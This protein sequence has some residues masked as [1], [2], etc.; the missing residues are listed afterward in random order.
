MS[1]TKTIVLTIT[2]VFFIIVAFSDKGESV[3]ADGN[4]LKR[5]AQETCQACHKTDSNAPVDTNSIKTHNSANTGSAKWGPNGWGVAGG[6]YGQFVCTT[7]HTPHDTNNIYLI[8]ETITAPNSPT[9]SFPGSTV[10][11]RTFSGIAGAT[12]GVMGDDFG[13]PRTSSTRICEICH[14]QNKFHN[15]NSANNAGGNAHNN[16]TDCTSCHDHKIAF[17]PSCRTCHTSPPA[18]GKHATHFGAGSAS[19]GNTTIQSSSS[20]YGFSCGICHNGTHRNTTANPH[21]VEVIFTGIATQDGATTAAYT[22]SA[23]SVDSPSGS[24]Y[25]FNYSNGMCSNTYC[26]GNYPGSGKNASVTFNTGTAV[27]G[28]CHDATN[29]TVPPSGSHSKHALSTNCAYPCIMCHKGI[30]SGS[31]PSGYTIADKSRHANGSV[32]W[33]FDTF[34]SSTATYSITSGNTPPSNGTTPRAYGTCSNTYCHSNGTAVSSGSIPANTSATWGS[35]TLACNSCHGSGTNNGMPNY[36]NGNPKANVHQAHVNHTSHPPPYTSWAFVM[37]CK[38][39]HVGTTTDDT[40]IAS[41]SLHVNRAYDVQANGSQVSFDPVSFTYTPLPSGGQCF[42][43]SCH[44]GATVY[45]GGSNGGTCSVSTCHQNPYYGQAL[46][47]ISVTPVNPRTE[48]NTAQQFS[49]IALY[50]NNVTQDITLPATWTSSNTAIAT[51]A[52]DPYSYGLVKTGGSKGT[53]T[54]TAQLGNVSG[55]TTLEVTD[56]RLVAIA[57]TPANSSIPLGNTKQF[58]AMGTY[59]DNSVLDITTSVSWESSTNAATIS[60][61][62]GSKGLATSKGVG[63][64]TVT[65]RLG[66]ISGNT[67]LTITPAQLASIAV[68][69]S[70]QSIAISSTQQFIATGIYTDGSMTDYTNQVTWSS[71][72][73]AVATINAAG[74][75]TGVGLSTSTITA[76]DP[77]TL[78]S[79]STTLTVVTLGGTVTPL[80]VNNGANWNDYVKNNG[81][82]TFT[83]TDTPCDGTE[84]SG[85]SACLHGGEMRKVYV[86]GKSTC[87]G[88][89]AS[90]ALGVFNWSCDGSVNPVRMI[91]DGLQDGKNLSD[92]IDLTGTP[93]WKAN[94]V[95]VSDSGNPYLATSYAVW[96]NN[97]VVV[98]NSGGNLT[99]SGTIYVNVATANP[100]AGYEIMADKVSLVIAPFVTLHTQSYSSYLIDASLNLSYKFLW[101]EGNFDTSNNGD[102]TGGGSNI[103]VNFYRVKFSVLRNVKVTKSLS[104]SG[105]YNFYLNNVSNSKVTNCSCDKG[106]DGFDLYTSS[107]NTF[108]DIT[109]S[110]QSNYGFTVNGSSINTFAKMKLFGN[111]GGIQIISSTNNSLTNVIATN[112]LG[113]GIFLTG[114]SY[115]TFKNVIASNNKGATGAGIYVYSSSNNNKFVNVNAFNNLNDGIHVDTSSNNMFANVTCANNPDS[116]IYLTYSTNSIIANVSAVNNWQGLLQS[117]SADNNTVENVAAANNGLYG[118]HLYTSSNNRFTGILKAGNNSNGDCSA[119]GGTNPGLVDGTCANNGASDATAVTGITLAV[120]FGA[121][122]S[123]D[124]VNPSGSTGVATYADITDWTNFENA[125]REWGVDSLSAFPGAGNRGSCTPGATCRIWD[126]TLPSSDTVIKGVLPKNATG[127]VANTVTH[128]WYV[129]PAPTSQ[130]NCDAEVPGS[131][132]SAGQCKNTFLRNAVELTGNGN[133]LCESN[134]TCLYTPNIGSYQGEGNLISAGTF[135]NGTTLTN[136]TLKQYDTNGH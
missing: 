103:A 83:A 120:S 43:I 88:L 108:S 136:I 82:N 121:K 109:A 112:N 81:S 31:G 72:N 26:H 4:L 70:N 100:S 7:C 19:Y 131:I 91:S 126:W 42:N 14:S 2:G 35:G 84:T 16:S 39:C 34:A 77:V 29:T 99:G 110:N 58:T 47:S 68:T 98:N 117:Y 111:S 107:Y 113:H 116:G 87:S 5:S 3:S 12:P 129:N 28:S 73:G 11:F 51:I 71:S 44:R 74:L 63:T 76:I 75:A 54:I 92:L 10:D 20:A 52:T 79:G 33:S 60:S 38:T 9:D 124:S 46:V 67:G 36:T 32:D 105:Y 101:V 97:P 17:M 95:T 102:G 41:R 130:A 135:T 106:N 1:G 65:A 64:T 80:Y 96:W 61:A 62:A 21:T 59:S 93:G 114:S 128:V 90:D 13:Q 119:F 27:C 85:Y 118:V 133:G 18:T 50:A 48:M 134:E 78:L 49:A 30:V 22:P 123:H 86:T 8:R 122:A 104:H 94:M 45:W 132:Y 55:S 127:N 53:T 89:T 125:Y 15:Y 57:V 115:N 37:T 69:P 24:G 23:Y 25:S 6:K 66:G 56:V 40:S